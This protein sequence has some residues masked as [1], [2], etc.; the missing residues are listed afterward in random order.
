MCTSSPKEKTKFEGFLKIVGTVKSEALPQIL[1]LQKFLSLAYTGDGTVQHPGQKANIENVPN[2]ISGTT[3]LTK[4]LAI[5]IRAIE[6]KDKAKKI[7]TDYYAEIPERPSPD[8]MY[9]SGSLV[10]VGAVYAAFDL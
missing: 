5:S 9:Y 4:Q 7:F 10:K 6:E 3:L 2:V 8:P 1:P